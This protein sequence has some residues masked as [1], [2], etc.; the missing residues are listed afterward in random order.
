MT[1]NKDK[2]TDRRTLIAAAAATAALPFMTT[3]TRAQARGTRVVV[4]LGGVD[5]P[6]EIAT[7]LESDI[8]RA[9][10]MAV[11]QAA[12]RTKFKSLPL[13]K[14]TLGIVLQRT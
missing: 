8:R 14:G 6:D 12:P 10:L 1:D 11:A 7:K 3:E 13:P 9:V 5:L 4:D 2:S